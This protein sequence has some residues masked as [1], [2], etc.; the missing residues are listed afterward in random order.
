MR[1]IAE[2][3][4]DSVK[5]RR[6]FGRTSW[7]LPAMITLASHRIALPLAALLAFG[8]AA[9]AQ[10][11]AP[12]P[13]ASPAKPKS[14]KPAAK[15]G[16]SKPAPE[17]AAALGP[18][19]ALL[20]QYAEWAAYAAQSGGSKVC[21]AL[22]KPASSQTTPANKPRDP[23]FFFVASRPAENVRNEVSVIA[24]YAFKPAT[25]ATIEIGPAKFAMYTQNDGAWI[26]NAAEEARLVETMR[27]GADLVVTGTSS[28]GTQSVDRYSLKGLSQALDR[29]AQE[30]K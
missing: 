23:V 4:R 8:S 6:K 7:E 17:A 27:K 3:R 24:G 14:A 2:C 19:P 18:K 20:G 15:P 12:N 9:A 30:C 11:P 1:P 13:A 28:R 26:K 10:Q 25:D 5:F 16:A 29:T 21:F 22:A